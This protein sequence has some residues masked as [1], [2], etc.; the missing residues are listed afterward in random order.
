MNISVTQHPAGLPDSTDDGDSSQRS[1]ST[2]RRAA[3]E[4]ERLDAAVARTAAEGRVSRAK[5]VEGSPPIYLTRRAMREAASRTA[6]EL[7]VTIATEAF[8]A[9]RI[10]V[11]APA[12]GAGGEHVLAARPVARRHRSGA[13]GAPAASPPA[14]LRR[15]GRRLAR[16]ITAG[17]SLLFI[18]SLVVVTSLPAQA[19]PAPDGLDPVIAQLDP[20]TQSLPPV[21]AEPTALLA[22]DEIV[23]REPVEVARATPDQRAA[24][25]TVADSEPAR[26]SY[27]GKPAF[28]QT[29]SMLETDYVQ[30]PFP[31]LAQLPISSPFG[32]RSGGFHGGTDIPLPA[33]QEILPIANGVV[34]AVWQGDNPG[35]GGYTVFIDH[36]INGQ[37]VQSWYSHMLPGSIRV[38]VGQ[39]VDITTVI[40]EVGSS[41]R[42]TG[43]HLHLELKNSDYVS[44]DPVLWLQTRETR[45][46]R[47]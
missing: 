41:G 28:P 4:G 8:T 29:W 45:L 12:L 7:E 47:G 30:T 15:E 36:N 22:R 24:L 20:E 3:R 46:E 39:V 11:D 32:Y 27:G 23:V 44:F 35:G 19:V 5:V 6:A 16:K 42:S 2:S 34:S 14:R 37:F 38:E 21:S 10:L 26:S 33:G 17:A 1:A 43:N 40:G 25:Q 9:P 31:S 18:G 13:I